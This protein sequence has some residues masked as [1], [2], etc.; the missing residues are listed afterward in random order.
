MKRRIAREKAVQILFQ[1]DVAEVQLPDAIDMV[2]ED[3]TG[4]S[5]EFLLSLVHGTLENLPAIDAEIQK[6]LRNWKLDRIANVD[7]SVLR[8]AF[9]ELMFDEATPDR[10]VLN[11][12]VELAKLFSDEQS[13]KFINGVLS[14]YLQA[15]ATTTES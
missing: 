14:A 5:T 7:R 1:L 9:Y 6:Y 2:M 10:V 12:A 8:L 3:S 15:G 4:E 13:Y 11:E